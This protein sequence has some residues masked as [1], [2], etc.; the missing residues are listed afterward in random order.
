ML[1]ESSPK[2]F[3]SH[4]GAEI[5]RDSAFCFKC[6]SPISSAQ[7]DPSPT[8]RRQKYEKG[9]KE[10]EK[11]QEKESEGSVSGAMFGGGTLIWLGVTFYLATSGQ[12][13]WSKWWP[14]F[15]SGLGILLMLLGLYHSIRSKGLFPFIGMVIGG[16]IISLIGL[17]WFYSVSM[18]LWPIMIILI[19][20]VII[21]FGLLGRKRVPRP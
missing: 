10:E 20:L 6:G 7:T 2:K 16:A 21:L 4:C 5:P 17:S 12:I 14:S 8:T 18:G 15:M 11:E 19:G 9:E 3:C 13:D 1:S